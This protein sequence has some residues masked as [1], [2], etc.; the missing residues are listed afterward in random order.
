M[1]RYFI[2]HFDP[3]PGLWPIITKLKSVVKIGLLTDQYPGMLDQ[4]FAKNILPPVTWDAI[5]DSTKV[6]YRKPAP[7]IYAL[8]EKKAGVAGSEILF[9]DNREK[10]L[11]PARARGWQTFFYDSRDYAKANQDLAAFVGS[12]SF[13]TST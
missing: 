11:V 6:G 4:I 13:R 8:A 3:N 12:L 5:V 1:R 2:D 7:E 9:I 10:N